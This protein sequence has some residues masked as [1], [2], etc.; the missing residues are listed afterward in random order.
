MPEIISRPEV[1]WTTMA[2]TSYGRL[3]KSTPHPATTSAATD[4]GGPAAIAE[5]KQASAQLSG[6]GDENLLVS[7]QHWKE[8][9]HF[10]FAPDLS[11]LVNPRKEDL[12]GFTRTLACYFPPEVDIGKATDDNF[13]NSGL[14]RRRVPT[15]TLFTTAPSLS[16]RYELPL[17]KHV[18]R[19][20]FRSKVS[21][22]RFD[23][24][25]LAATTLISIP[26]ASDLSSN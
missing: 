24:F 11:S 14:C 23:R 26:C 5:P 19:R 20:A 13:A 7:E 8:K 18:R 6:E 25:H 21:S 10:A 22:G 2:N 16:R 3:F 12:V 17:P 15:S 4:S 9:L 1:R